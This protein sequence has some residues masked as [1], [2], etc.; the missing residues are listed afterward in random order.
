MFEIIDRILIRIARR[1]Q[2]TSVFL[3]RYFA[4]KHGVS[5]GLYSYGCFDARRVGPG[6]NIGRYCSIAPTAYIL[7]RN[8]AVTSISMHPFLYG[9]SLPFSVKAKI[10]YRTCTI[11]DDVWLGHGSI[12]LPSVM[13]IGR[14]AIVAAGAVVTKD[15]PAY[16]IVAGNPARVVRSRFT[17][18][19]IERIEATKWWE[20]SAAEFSDFCK[21]REAAVL[22]P[23]L[24]EPRV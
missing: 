12:V 11:E 7:R 9:E 20:M 5:V 15:V 14:G 10:E 2:M 13:H 8:H 4:R 1:N 19:V 16:T 24:L 22:A 21:N 17:P 23:E 6:T 3:R 18:E